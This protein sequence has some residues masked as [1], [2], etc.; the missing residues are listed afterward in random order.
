MK[1]KSLKKK[2]TFFNPKDWRDWFLYSLVVLF[3]G[4][5]IKVID[6]PWTFIFVMLFGMV[7]VAILYKTLKK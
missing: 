1:S 7:T 6:T 5:E 4:I 2:R 3:L